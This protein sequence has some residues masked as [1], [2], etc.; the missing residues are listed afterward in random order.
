[1]G[2]RLLRRLSMRADISVTRV[3][4]RSALQGLALFLPYSTLQ[5]VVWQQHHG[6]ESM[7]LGT[8]DKLLCIL[9]VVTVETVTRTKQLVRFSRIG[10]IANV[11]QPLRISGQQVLLSS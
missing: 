9:S 3:R 8:M 4:S 11:E 6:T 7:T 10:H 5:K 1:M 2:Y